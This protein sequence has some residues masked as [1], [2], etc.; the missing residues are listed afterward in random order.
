MDTKKEIVILGSGA[1]GQATGKGFIKKGYHVVFVDVDHGIVKKLRDEGFESIHVNELKERSPDL[2]FITIQIATERKGP[3]VKEMEKT[4]KEIGA[5]LKKTTKYVLVVVRCT[6]PPLT[7]KRFVIP[8]LERSSGKKAGKDFGVCFN[9]EYMRER[10]G[11]EDFLNPKVII[12]GSEDERS[13]KSLGEFYKDFPVNIYY[14]KTEEAE[15][16][17][18]IHNLYNACKISFFNEQREICKEM[19][20]DADKI[21]K[22]V[23]ESA[24]ASWNFEYGIKDR[25]PYGGSCLPKDT[26]GFLRWAKHTLG[27]RL[28]LLEGIIKAND[29]IKDRSF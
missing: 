25:G 21:F 15:M 8:L 10:F 24:E 22:A 19:K 28:Y 23:T 16:H 29:R 20:L 26:K 14:F 2:F 3:Q 11:T 12:I 7:T 18:Y 6:V 5:Y 4:L 1:V 27:R 13:A 9:P 17:K